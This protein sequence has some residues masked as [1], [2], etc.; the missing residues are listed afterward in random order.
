MVYARSAIFY[1]LSL[2]MYTYTIQHTLTNMTESLYPIN[3]Y[4]ETSTYVS[5]KP[6]PAHNHDNYNITIHFN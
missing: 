6:I 2:G 4:E 1:L 5:I 3:T